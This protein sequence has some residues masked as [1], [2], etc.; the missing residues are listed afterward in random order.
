MDLKKIYKETLGNTRVD[1]IVR[2]TYARF[3]G[4]DVLRVVYYREMEAV[5]ER[6]LRAD[7]NC[8]DVGCHEG[9][10]LQRLVALSP[11]G[12]HWAFE[13]IPER[14]TRLQKRFPGV[15]VMNLALSD[16]EKRTVFNYVPECDALSGLKR[17]DYPGVAEVQEIPVRTV[18]LDHLLQPEF[19][20]DLLKIDVEGAELEVLR[21]AFNTLKKWR[22]ITIFQHGL[23][24]A[25]YYDTRP[26][27]LY[28]LFGAA[29]MRI[30][31]MDAWL[32][33]RPPLNRDRFVRQFY[34]RLNYIFIAH[35]ALILG[36]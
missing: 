35:A 34:R 24:S 23:G 1:T 31:L 2:K 9:N 8:I 22:P 6:V 14:H 15:Q 3:F 36:E 16:R 18:A 17:R 10:V 33:G 19:R 27:Q 21:G 4:N 7:S 29:G 26:E 5:F 25:E 12:F 11:K 30:S 13:P 20:V 32:A 28:D